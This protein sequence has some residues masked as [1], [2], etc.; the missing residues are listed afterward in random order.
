MVAY[1]Q[2]ANPW[3]SDPVR[4]DFKGDAVDM[5]CGEV[6][7]TKLSSPDYRYEEWM[8]FP[9]DFDR[10]RVPTGMVDMFVTLAVLM[11]KVLVSPVYCLDPKLKLL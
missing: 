6:D 9:P 11:F 8:S 2:H 3:N 5:S 7:P 1:F 4:R 10:S